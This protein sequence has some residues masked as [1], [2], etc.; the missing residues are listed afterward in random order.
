MITVYTIGALENYSRPEAHSKA[1][2]GSVWFTQGEAMPYVDR[3][4]IQG[5]R[6]QG[7]IFEVLIPVPEEGILED[8]VK[9]HPSGKWLVLQKNAPLGECVHVGVDPHVH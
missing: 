4:G 5:V 7:G 6:V 8:Y 1:T 2:G 9:P 3:V